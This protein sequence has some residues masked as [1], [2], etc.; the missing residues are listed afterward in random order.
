M[1]TLT[2]THGP[3][4]SNIPN[5]TSENA[6]EPSSHCRSLCVRVWL[7]RAF[8]RFH[9]GIAFF[10]RVKPLKQRSLAKL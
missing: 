1:H 2:H 8:R 6:S 9:D 7:A 4:N 10:W 5:L 3:R